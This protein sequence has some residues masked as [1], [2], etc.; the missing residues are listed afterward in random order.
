MKKLSVG[1]APSGQTKIEAR[2]VSASP[3]ASR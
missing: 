2:L 1:I 3:L